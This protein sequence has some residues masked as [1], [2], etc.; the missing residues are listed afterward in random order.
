MLF[1]T[2]AHLKR[3]TFHDKFT[4][5]LVMAGAVVKGN[6]IFLPLPLYGLR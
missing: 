1:C 3:A 4:E 5:L 2:N 6:P